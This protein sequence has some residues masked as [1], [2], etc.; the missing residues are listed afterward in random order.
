VAL[1]RVITIGV[2]GFTS[3]AFFSA[4]VTAKVDLFCD[5]R[6]RRGVRGR[7]YAFANSQRL[8]ARLRDFGIRYSHFPELA[9]TS[10][11]RS[12]QHQA[13]REVGVAKRERGRLAD[14]FTT[15]YLGLLTGPAALAA[16]DRIASTASVPAL[17]CVERLPSACHRSLVAERLA[18]DTIPVEHLVP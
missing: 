9:P 14:S 18:R 16:L 4:L 10:E 12:L 2:Y 11:I 15:A 7:D 6:A 1:Q 5:L 3:D 13:D 17:F 8:Q